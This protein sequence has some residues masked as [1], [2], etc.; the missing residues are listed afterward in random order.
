MKQ[1]PVNITDVETIGSRVKERREELNWTQVELATLA[2]VSPGTIGN[3]ESGIREN[4]RQLLEIAD[5]LGVK[6]E[7]LK[8]GRLPKLAD[9]GNLTAP[10]MTIQAGNVVPITKISVRDAVM[11]LGQALAGRDAEMEL[12]PAS[13]LLRTLALQPERASEVADRLEGLLGG[14]DAEQPMFSRKAQ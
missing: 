6:P 13:S 2:G 11:A 1:V 8:T 7:W 9:G 3:L 10:A 4:P 5:A 12:A 14:G